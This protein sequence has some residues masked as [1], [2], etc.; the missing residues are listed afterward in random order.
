MSASKWTTGTLS[1]D[2]RSHRLGLENGEIDF[3]KAKNGWIFFFGGGGKFER[4]NFLNTQKTEDWS[5]CF[6]GST[7]WGDKKKDTVYII[8]I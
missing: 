8:Y 7:F 5:F 1:A 4:R 2:P 6:T 3:S